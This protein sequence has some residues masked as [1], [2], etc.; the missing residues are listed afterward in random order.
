MGEKNQTLLIYLE[1][2]FRVACIYCYDIKYK[3]IGYT[4]ERA[5]NLWVTSPA[6]TDS[7]HLDTG[8]TPVG[9]ETI[10]L[11]MSVR[12]KHFFNCSSLYSQKHILHILLLNKLIKHKH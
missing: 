2:P 8:Q 1:H 7:R 3:K 5:A 6:D 4:Y 9:A 10:I 12:Q 11:C